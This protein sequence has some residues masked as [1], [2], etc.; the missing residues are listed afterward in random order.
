MLKL[1]FDYKVIFIAKKTNAKNIKY[2]IMI[3]YRRNL[4]GRINKKDLR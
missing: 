2:V 3:L 1:I 4:S